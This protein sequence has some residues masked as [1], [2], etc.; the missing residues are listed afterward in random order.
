M[1]E[2]SPCICMLVRFKMAQPESF[3]TLFLEGQ[4]GRYHGT[5]LILPNSNSLSLICVSETILKMTDTIFCAKG[6]ACVSREQLPPHGLLFKTRIFRPTLRVLLANGLLALKAEIFL[7]LLISASLSHTDFSGIFHV[8]PVT[9][10]NN[11]RVIS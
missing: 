7:P 5:L 8:Q 2:F 11:P 10:N 1:Q 4:P 9:L 6:N 3:T